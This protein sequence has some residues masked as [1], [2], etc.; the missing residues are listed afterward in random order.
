MIYLISS[1]S[2]YLVDDEIK[3]IFN[4]LDDVEIVDYSKTTIEDIITSINYVSLFNDEKKM[5]VKNA[6]LFLSK[7]SN[8]TNILEKY[9]NEPNPNSTLVFVVYDKVDERKKI[10]KI[11]K[12][13][14]NYIY[15]K[16][17][18]PKDIVDRIINIFKEKKYKI[19]YDNAKYIANNCLNN[20]DLVVNEINKVFLYYLK[21]QE[22]RLEDLENI[23]SKTMEDNNFKFVDAVINKNLKS[24]KILN[25]LKIQKVEPIV[26]LNLLARE[27]RL[28]LIAK[29]LYQ[30]N[31]SKD[32]IA[33]ELKLQDWQVDKA[34]SNSYNYSIKELEDKIIALTNLDYMIKTG[35]VDK[36]LG[37]E[38]F[39][40]KD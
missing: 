10:T 2:Y 17:L 3:K 7:T 25:D 9:L 26:L 40:L 28:M 33:K 32:N 5:I 20:Y 1:N 6:N 38:L 27:Y 29:D 8:D 16:P 30:R 35:N 11:I 12:E 31:I 15:L 14:Y 18:S 39:I 4:N 36:Y 23:I 13:K 34:I 22:I 19:S 37:L 21:P 24:L